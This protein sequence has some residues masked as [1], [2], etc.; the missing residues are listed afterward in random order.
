MVLDAGGGVQVFQNFSTPFKIMNL[1]QHAA[2]KL[3]DF[4]KD[5][6]D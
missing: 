5:E 6:K 2:M 3:I 1:S 4:L